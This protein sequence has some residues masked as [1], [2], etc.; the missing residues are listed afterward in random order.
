MAYDEGLAE[1]VREVIATRAEADEIKMFGGL[2]FMVNTHMAVGVTGEGLLLK[3]GK[4]HVADAIARG[5]TQPMM[6]DRVMTG[7]VR[8]GEDV[9]ECDGLDEWVLPWVEAALALPPKP[10]KRRAV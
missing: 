8:I 6:G 5:G 1:R 9:L 3:V 10:P 4:E 2:C 7:V